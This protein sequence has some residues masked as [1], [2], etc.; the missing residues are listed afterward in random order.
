MLIEEKSWLRVCMQLLENTISP[1]FGRKVKHVQ[2]LQQLRDLL[3]PKLEA[4]PV[5]PAV[6]HYDE[7][8]SSQASPN[9]KRSKK[10]LPPL[11]SP[12]KAKKPLP[13]APRNVHRP[14]VSETKIVSSLSPLVPPR[15][16]ARDDLKVNT[17][18]YQDISP[19]TTATT[20]TTTSDELYRPSS[21]GSRSTSDPMTERSELGSMTHLRSHRHRNHGVLRRAISGP[22]TPSSSTKQNYLPASDGGD[23][24]PPKLTIRGKQVT[25]RTRRSED[26]NSRVGGL[27][28]LFE[29]RAAVINNMA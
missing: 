1:K 19:P 15:R 11:P 14:T 8:L 9:N 27:K 23:M 29:E 13:P 4:I 22:L 6:H 24:P 28:A 2:S 10:S 20:W 5:P 16:G 25:I 21:M 3:G 12:A 26:G 17:E 18:I 7:L